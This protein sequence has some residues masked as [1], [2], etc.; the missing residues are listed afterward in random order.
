MYDPEGL[1]MNN[2]CLGWFKK[3][4]LAKFINNLSEFTVI[5]LNT[6]IAI[7]LKYLSEFMKRH[8]TISEQTTGF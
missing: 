7:A 8:T 6:L 2:Y 3:F 5:I 1:D 4:L